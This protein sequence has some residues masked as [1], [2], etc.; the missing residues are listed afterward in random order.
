MLEKFLNKKV[1]LVM[2]TNGTKIYQKLKNGI[3]IGGGGTY[4]D[5]Y[6]VEG[7]VTNLDSN[8]IEINNNLVIQIKYIISIE[9]I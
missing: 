3:S 9:N 2:A 1:K 7:I 8:F 5:T 4:F 6:D